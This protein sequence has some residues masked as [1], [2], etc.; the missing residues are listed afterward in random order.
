MSNKLGG[1]VN[2]QQNSIMNKT[3]SF[4]YQSYLNDKNSNTGRL[5]F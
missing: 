1:K 5:D 2:I 3:S 4:D